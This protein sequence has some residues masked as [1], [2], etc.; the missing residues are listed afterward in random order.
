VP[1]LKLS[2]RWEGR[3]AGRAFGFR[4]P[5]GGAEVRG[6]VD[7]AATAP[8]YAVQHCVVDTYSGEVLLA[9]THDEERAEDLAARLNDATGEP[10]GD[11]PRGRPR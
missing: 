3:R 9:P 11:S 8:L 10:P 7:D 2:L 5:S 1:V 6:E 4:L